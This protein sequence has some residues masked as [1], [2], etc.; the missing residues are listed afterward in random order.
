MGPVSD[1][2]VRYAELGQVESVRDG[3]AAEGCAHGEEGISMAP[4]EY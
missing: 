3:A 1:G 4:G 2:G